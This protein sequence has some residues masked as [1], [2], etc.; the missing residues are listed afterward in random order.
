MSEGKTRVLQGLNRL[1][2]ARNP[3]A[4]A[5]SFS[6]LLVTVR[7][8]R[9]LPVAEPASLTSRVTLCPHLPFTSLRP[10]AA[11]RPPFAV[12]PKL[13]DPLE[14]IEVLTPGLH[15]SLGLFWPSTRG[16]ALL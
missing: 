10:F 2:L 6:S 11:F 7:V 9:G 12:S 15:R 3:T 16:I 1:L 14:S 13:S 8:L 4:A 5:G